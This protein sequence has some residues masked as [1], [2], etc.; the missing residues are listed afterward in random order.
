MRKLKDTRV[1]TTAA[2]LTAICTVLGFFKI[3]LTNMVELRFAFLPIA[4]SGALFGPGIGALVGAL[5]D[6][7]GYLVKPTGMFFPGFTLASL[8]GGAIYGFFFYKKD[9]SLP[10]IIGAE[11]LRVLVCNLLINTASLSFLYGMPFWASLVSRLPK[12]AV[13]FPINCLLLAALLK[14]VFKNLPNRY[15]AP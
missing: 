2:L 4:V 8:L 12:N 1:L 10:R 13:M 3:P 5:S 6:I 9:L 14:P 7:L 11:A 15:Q